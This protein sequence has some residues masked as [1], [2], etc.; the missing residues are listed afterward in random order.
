MAKRDFAQVH[1]P[2]KNR[3]RESSS[4]SA[5]M[6]GVSLLFTGILAFTGGYMVGHTNNSTDTLQAEKSALTTQIEGL[7]KQVGDLQQQLAA[8]LE[9]EK[10]AA[11]KAAAER[12]GDL[13]FYSEL[14]RQKVMPSPL[15]DTGPAAEQQH[16]GEDIEMYSDLP[17]PVREQEA[18]QTLASVERQANAATSTAAGSPDAVYK[19]QVGSF[20]RRSDAEVLLDRMAL[21]GIRATVSEAQVPNLGTRYR[22]FTTTF[23]GMAEA[24]GA[25]SLL[26]EKLGIE[27][28]LMREQ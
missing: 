11:K 16:R 15:G 14:P 20:V 6:A 1:T 3:K 13:T 28:L 12:V 26:R 25:K 7:Q 21:A 8:S 10:P 22:V 9:R 27:G 5:A 24:E 19:L 17:P 4:M 2:A 23:T 18:P